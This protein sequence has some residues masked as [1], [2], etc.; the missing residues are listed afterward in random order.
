MEDLS[1]DAMMKLMQHLLLQG[2]GFLQSLLDLQVRF[3]IQVHCLYVA[4]SLSIVTAEQNQVCWEMFSIVYLQYTTHL[5]ALCSHYTGL[6]MLV[7]QFTN[8][9][10]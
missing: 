6:G 9:G 1:S 5:R 10:R 2:P 4:N 3:P 8:L 7:P